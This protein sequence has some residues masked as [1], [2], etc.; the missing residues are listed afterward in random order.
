MI[1]TFRPCATRGFSAEIRQD[2]NRKI[3][4]WRNSKFDVF[5]SSGKCQSK[6]VL[7]VF[8]KEKL[9]IFKV[10]MCWLPL[11]NWGTII[12]VT[13]THTHTRIHTNAHTVVNSTRVSFNTQYCASN[14][15][16][17]LKKGYASDTTTTKFE[18]N[19]Q[20]SSKSRNVSLITV[21][22]FKCTFPPSHS[23]SSHFSL[24]LSFIIIYLNCKRVRLLFS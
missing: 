10:L 15:S 6:G 11:W 13:H 24:S 21:F 14:T 19:I 1:G 3:E 7:F 4:N 22:K 8:V 16:G 9:K 5:G 23:W 12:A 2:H 17:P 20:M 18:N